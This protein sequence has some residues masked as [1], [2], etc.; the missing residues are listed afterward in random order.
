M[1]GTHLFNASRLDRKWM[2]VFPIKAVK[3]KKEGS[4]S[5]RGRVCIY[6]GKGFGSPRL[7]INFEQGVRGGT[8]E[9]KWLTSVHICYCPVQAE[10]LGKGRHCSAVPYSVYLARSSPL[11]QNALPL[12]L[13]VSSCHPRPVVFY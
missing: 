7:E 9:G 11:L 5:I 6:S 10:A 8:W 1:V 2:A 3:K 4:K 13:G 12:P